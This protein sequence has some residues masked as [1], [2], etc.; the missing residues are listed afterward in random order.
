MA[1]LTLTWVHVHIVLDLVLN[2]LELSI[3]PR[4]QE[5]IVSVHLFINFRVFRLPET[6]KEPFGPVFL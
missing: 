6:L 4:S 1:L 2:N 3:I 5:T